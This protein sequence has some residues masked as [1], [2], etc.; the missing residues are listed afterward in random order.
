MMY[1]HIM[2]CGS[3]LCVLQKKA[4]GQTLVDKVADHLNLLEKDYFAMSFRANDVK[5]SIFCSEIDHSE[6]KVQCFLFFFRETSEMLR[7]LSQFKSG[8]SSRSLT[9]QSH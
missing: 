5:V 8:R 9:K 4:K 1:T 7:A 2:I 6:T 3:M